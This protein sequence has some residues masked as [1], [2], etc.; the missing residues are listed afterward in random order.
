VWRIFVNFINAALSGVILVVDFIDEV[1][2]VPDRLNFAA[3]TTKSR[4]G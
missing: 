4:P 1:R 2:Q 3:Y